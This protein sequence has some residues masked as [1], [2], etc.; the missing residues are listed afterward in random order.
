MSDA[1][2]DSSAPIPVTRLVYR[3]NF[4][5]PPAFRERHMPLTPPAGEL[6]V[7]VSID[8]LRARFVGPGWPV[9]EGARVRLRSDVPGVYLFDG[10]GGRPLAPGRLAAWFE[11]RPTGRVRSRVRVRREFGRRKQAK[12][13]ESEPLCSLLAEWTN[14]P[15][16]DVERRCA[17]GALPPGFRFGPWSAELT[18]IVPMRLPRYA[19][20]ADHVDAPEPI[21]PVHGHAMLDRLGL[22]GIEPVAAPPEGTQPGPLRLVNRT[23][24]RAVVVAQGA[25]VAWVDAG[26][27]FDLEGLSPGTYRIGALRPLGVLR[28]A[29]R[30]IQVPGE[31]IIGGGRKWKWRPRPKDEGTDSDTDTDSATGSATDPDT[32]TDPDSDTATGSA[33]GSD[34]DP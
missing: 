26:A 18:A 16:E 8:R 3:V 22:A 11:G 29:P 21:A 30:R 15:R 20:R 12:V 4:V 32:D 9:Q 5:V 1:S 7:D 6:H 24:T 27:R 23:D 13:A 33:T 31:F 10:A 28:M 2:E 19:M 14:Q 34:S 25:P 17:G